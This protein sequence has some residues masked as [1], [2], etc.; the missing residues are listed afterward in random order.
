MQNLSL[1][2]PVLER[3][4]TSS[5]FVPDNLFL[6]VD[7]YA[8]L[9]FRPLQESRGTLGVFL[10]KEVDPYRG[11]QD[12]R[13]K[14]Y[15]ADPG[16]IDLLK[17]EYEAAALRLVIT[18]SVNFVIV[19]VSPLNENL[20]KSKGKQAYLADLI[21]TVVKTEAADHHWRFSLPEDL[22]ASWDQRLISNVGAVPIRDVESRHD[23]ADIL[24]WNDSVYFMFYKKVDQLEGF[25][26]GDKWFSSEARAAM[27]TSLN[28]P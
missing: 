14:A 27:R 22:N 5:L 8:N 17:S 12:V 4:L 11:V 19:K 21:Q 9:L 6:P 26:P 18:E 28:Q 13:W 2:E 16:G 1:N 3:W 25:L 7:A 10:K 15:A 23:R 20:T 24:I